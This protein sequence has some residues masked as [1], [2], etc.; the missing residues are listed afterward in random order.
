M[1]GAG[2]LDIHQQKRNET[3]INKQNINKYLASHKKVSLKCITELNKSNKTIKN[4][5]SQ[6][7]NIYYLELHKCFLRQEYKKTFLNL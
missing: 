4:K 6:E 1:S 7:K 3:K 2:Q 5:V